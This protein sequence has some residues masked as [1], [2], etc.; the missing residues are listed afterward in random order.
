M[1]WTWPTAGSF[2]WDQNS[3][4]AGPI[5][6]VD[7]VRGIITISPT[8]LASR[9][10]HPVR[11]YYRTADQHNVQLERSPANFI[12]VDPAVDPRFLRR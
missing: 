10:G 4:S 8:L 3:T 11:I 1:M 6:G 5:S 7:F 9:L 2:V 12:E